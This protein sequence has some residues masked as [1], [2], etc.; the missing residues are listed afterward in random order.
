MADDEYIR[1]CKFAGAIE[2]TRSDRGRADCYVCSE[3]C[4]RLSAA[5]RLDREYAQLLRENR[6]LRRERQ[7]LLALCEQHQSARIAAEAERDW[8]REQLREMRAKA[9]RGEK[10]ACLS[11]LKPHQEQPEGG[12]A[13]QSQPPARPE[14]AVDEPS[15]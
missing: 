1:P 8:A 12:P 9:W 4:N 15:T 3:L 10:A 2:C 6:Q 13:C 14:V 5:V 11:A 7:R